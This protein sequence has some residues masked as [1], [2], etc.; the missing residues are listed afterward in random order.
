MARAYTL[1]NMSL[2]KEEAMT[3]ITTYLETNYVVPT[4]YEI[5]ANLNIPYTQAWKVLHALI[6]EGKLILINSDS[7]KHRIYRVPGY[8]IVKE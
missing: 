3:Y 2:L 7:Y 8:K 6:A 4:L 5:A 1:R